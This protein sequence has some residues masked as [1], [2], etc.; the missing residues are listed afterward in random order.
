[1]KRSRKRHFG[2]T[3]TELLVAMGIAGIIGLY[4]ARQLYTAIKFT[5]QTQDSFELEKAKVSV[6]RELRKVFSRGRTIATT[7]PGTAIDGTT[8]YPV[9]APGSANRIGAFTIAADLRPCPP[10]NAVANVNQFNPQNSPNN[11]LTQVTFMC[12]PPITT[13]N[14]NVASPFGGNM[15]VPNRCRVG[16]PGLT[17]N[18]RRNGVDV[19]GRCYGNFGQTGA[20]F[21]GIRLRPMGFDFSRIPLTVTALCDSADNF[22]SNSYISPFWCGPGSSAGNCNPPPNPATICTNNPTQAPTQL[23]YASF[24]TSDRVNTG[25]AAQDRLT[26]AADIATTTEFYGR[27]ENQTNAHLIDC[28]RGVND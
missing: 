6:L 25:Q 3:L 20:S 10:G 24:T 17:I 7:G 2:F 27:L 16:T 23:F 12:C 14:V 15:N 18:Y 13:A 21:T 28:G 19:G 11:V 1:M 4:A 5:G 22:S 8:A 26:V 9:D